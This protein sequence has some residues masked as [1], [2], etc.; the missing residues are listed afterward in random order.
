MAAVTARPLNYKSALR[1]GGR[2][3]GSDVRIRL[4]KLCKDTDF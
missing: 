2:V 4:V 3:L 1:D